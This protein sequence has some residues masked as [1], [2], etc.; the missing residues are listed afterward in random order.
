MYKRGK[1]V[2]MQVTWIYCEVTRLY[3]KLTTREAASPKRENEI[4]GFIHRH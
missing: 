4:R 3:I 2:G 1:V